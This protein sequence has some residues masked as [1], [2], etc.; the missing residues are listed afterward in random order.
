MRASLLFLVKQ[1]RNLSTPVELF[2][3]RF[4]M[5][6]TY[7][8]PQFTSHL[9]WAI[10]TRFKRSIKPIRHFCGLRFSFLIN[11][12]CELHNKASTDFVVRSL[13]EAEVSIRSGFTLHPSKTVAYQNS[14]LLGLYRFLVDL[15]SWMNYYLEDVYPF[16]KSF[17][18]VY[19]AIR[20]ILDDHFL[21]VPLFELLL[22]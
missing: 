7:T 13:G 10:L 15:N 9:S 6:T 14:V 22:H 20:A 3:N 19:E 2:R 21:I 5:R 11:L 16:V 8:F 17:L 4:G 12:V 18:L 1:T